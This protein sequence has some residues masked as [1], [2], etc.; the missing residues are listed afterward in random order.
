MFKYNLDEEKKIREYWA[1]RQI[2][3]KFRKKN[4]ESKNYFYMMDG[5]PYATGHI[6]LGT[7]LN[8]VLKDITFRYKTMR[9][10]NVFSRVGFDTHGLPIEN[11]VEKEL[12][13]K[14]KSD[15]EKYGVD[16]F[17]NKCIGFATKHI[18]D[19]TSAF[20]N[21]GVWMQLE[22][23]Y[24]TLDPDYIEGLWT[25]F[26]KADDKKLLYQGKYPVYVCPHCGTVVAYNEIE[27]AKLTDTSIFVKFP[28]ENKDSEFLVIWTTTPWTL[29]ANMG[30]MVHP[31]FDY[32]Y[33]KVDNEVWIIAKELVD[34]LMSKLNK[35]F[36][37]IKIVKGKELEGV[38]Y[39]NPLKDNLNLPEL[40]NSYRVILSERYVNLEDG[41]GLVHCAPGHG[42]EDYD[43]GT[44]SNLPVFCPVNIEGIY[45]DTA[46]KYK[47]MKV[48]SA[49]KIIIEDLENL[50]FLITKTN[51][52]HD[53][54]TCWRCHSPLL[55]VAL[56]QWFFKIKDIKEDLIK[57]NE[58]VNWTPKWGKDRFRDWLQNIND[59]PISRNRYWG[60]PIP[61][62]VCDTCGKHKVIG[63]YKEL[64]KKTGK[65]FDKSLLGVHK[66]NI[67]KYT[68][69]CECG[70][71][72]KRIPDVLDVWFDSGATSWGALNYPNFDNE[73]NKYWPADLNIEGSDQFRGWWNS[74]T[75]LSYITFGRLPFKAIS[76]H[77]M[78]LD[79]N[80]REMHKSI[81]NVIS[82]EEV[83]DKENRDFLRY[84]L[85]RESRGTDFAFDYSLF[86]D[87][88]RFI[89]IFDN[90]SN[91]L[92]TY[93]DINLDLTDK[94]ILPTKL[95]AEDKWVLSRLNSVKKEILEAYD[96]YLYYKVS[97]LFEEFLMVDLSR[98]YLK[99][100]K[101]REDKE[102]LSKIISYVFGNLLRLLAPIMPHY[103]EYVYKQ[104]NLNSIHLTDIT[105]YD[106]SLINKDIEEE[107]KL[108]L[109]VL[110]SGLNLR[111]KAK[112]RLRWTLPKAYFVSDKKIIKLKPVL[113]KMLNVNEV[114]FEKP[115][116]KEVESIETDDFKLF[117]NKDYS[118][119]IKDNWFVQE[120]RRAIQNER[121]KL[122][123][124]P[125]E[126]KD[127]ELYVDKSVSNILKP[128]LENIE[129]NTNT[130][131]SLYEIREVVEKEKPLK[132]FDKEVHI[133]FK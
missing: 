32:A 20:D 47:G 109:N 105:D 30:V 50:G 77:G 37:I 84:F 58:K 71:T 21:L 29:P 17:V 65:P 122:H 67:D 69:S 94:K 75:I 117:V 12:N 103:T 99:I 125:K 82:P 106:K 22:D 56:K 68:F 131:I 9:G 73:F 127:L 31:K 118:Q 2:N 129:K 110:Q 63:S 100:V 6:H 60:T 81:G 39:I 114:L 3:E 91:Y 36:E 96:T 49:N 13:F 40:L 55:M 33:V 57:L 116:E 14:N 132:I 42:K 11:K 89:N 113:E 44:K 38:K 119:D 19:M 98:V 121:K 72:M 133:V 54:P 123:F 85:T 92:K 107:M 112:L 126:L 111:E 74:Q 7:T 10:Y 95:N 16:K 15:I 35:T 28:I 76:V 93:L 128:S 5:P 23:P 46:G 41:T 53:Y 52:T 64:E 130:K 120:I 34:K 43:A 18:K 8:K 62:W 48:K 97:N 115:K 27:Y 88:H 70:G 83:I 80:K 1:E 78:V 124:T 4:K 90:I 25:T 26:K 61:I 102:N 66:P 59:W 86:K 79:I 51:I 101:G 45:D 108:L 24:L 104:F 87:I